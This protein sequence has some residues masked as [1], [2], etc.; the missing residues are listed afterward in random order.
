MTVVNSYIA[1]NGKIIHVQR[2]NVNHSKQTVKS[3]TRI[4]KGLG[5]LPHEI[6]G[7]GAAVAG[8]TGVGALTIIYNFR[9][10]HQALSRAGHAIA[11][12]KPHTVWNGML[13]A[14][15]ATFIATEATKL[16]KAPAAIRVVRK[17]GAEKVAKGVEKARS[18]VS[19]GASRAGAF[20]AEHPVV[21]GEAE[22]FG[23]AAAVL[24]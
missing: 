12:I 9:A 16:K 24:V 7:L 6:S 22:E 13:N 21:V 2:D 4:S 8:V 11:S 10:L 5:I 3:S 23:E 15:N 17:K 20:A 14:A 18:L 19:K 1:N